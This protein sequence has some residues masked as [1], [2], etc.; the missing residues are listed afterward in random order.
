MNE[1]GKEVVSE[2]EESREGEGVR[3]RKVEMETE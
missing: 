2:R 1:E 3:E